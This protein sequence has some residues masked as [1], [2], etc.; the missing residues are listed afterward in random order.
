MS[1]GED[2]ETGALV[3][4]SQLMNR[5]DQ[6][7]AAVEASKIGVWEWNAVTGETSF[8]DMWYRMLGLEPGE[9][10]E[11]VDSWV[12]LVHPEDRERTFADLEAYLKGE[13]EG[14]LNVH[15]LRHKAGHWVWVRDCGLTT[16]ETD[17]GSPH[18]LIGTHV[19]VSELKEI[20]TRLREA[21]ERAEASERAKNRFLANMSHELRTPMTGILGL[22]E[23][24]LDGSLTP[25]DQAH[26]ETLHSSAQAL[27][28]LLNDLLELTLLESG[29]TAFLSEPFCW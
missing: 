18:I 23:L 26:M 28:R 21:V 5:Y 10:P 6:L 19:D 13:N 16:L 8:N 29:P 4:G 22:A 24:L 3:P 17:E 9:L 12:D 15:R 27:H 1:Q 14:Y 2:L 25:D 20:E 7:L 11:H